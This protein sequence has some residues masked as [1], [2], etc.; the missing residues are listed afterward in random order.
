MAKKK[1]TKES[2]KKRRTSLYLIKTP[3]IL[4]RKAISMYPPKYI[5]S[6]KREKQKE[7]EMKKG[8][9]C[10]ERIQRKDIYKRTRKEKTPPF[11]LK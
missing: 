6:Q 9:N 8:I 11:S 10:K 7:Q 5:S 4:K 1:K 3:N 2:R